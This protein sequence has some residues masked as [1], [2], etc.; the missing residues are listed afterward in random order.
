MEVEPLPLPRRLERA[1]IDELLV[2]RVP[3]R[4][5]FRRIDVREGLLLHGEQGWGECS[6]FWDYDAA[7][8]AS[9][10]RA[11]IEAATVR[12]PEPLRTQ[13]PV[14]VTVPVVDPPT[15]ARL[16]RDSGGCTTAK[17]KVADPR[18][19]LAE[20]C[21]RVAAVREALGPGGRIRVDAN[22]AWDVEEAVAAIA[23]LDEAAGGLE[24]VEQPCPS[25]AALAAVRAR[26]DVPVAADES[27]RRAEDPVAVVRAGAA[28]IIIVKVQPLGGVLRA[29]EVVERSGLDAVVSSALDSSVGISVAAHLAGCLPCLD[30]ACGLATVEL[31]DGDVTDRPLLPVDGTIPLTRAGVDARPSPSGRLPGRLA[32]RWSARLEAMCGELG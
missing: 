5:R 2:F 27:V 28:D 15:A 12:L 17:V 22:A 32:E 26:V 13:V 21:A 14:N 10:L 8:S 19:T 11:G 16:V 4:H 3:L 9:W 29:L 30:H 20:D 1:G 24:Y 18:S 6:P 23:G 25:V 7:E 31:F